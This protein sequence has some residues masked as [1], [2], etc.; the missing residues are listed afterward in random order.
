MAPEKWTLPKIGAV[1][2]VM[3]TENIERDRK[4]NALY[5]DVV[6]GNSHPSLCSVVERHERW[7]N[8]VNRL[9]WIIVTAVIGQ[10]VVALFTTGVLLYAL[11][12]HA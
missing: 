7:I 4:I 1:L 2:T 6:T 5:E 10:F 9:T 3:Q 8:T 11:L 12:T